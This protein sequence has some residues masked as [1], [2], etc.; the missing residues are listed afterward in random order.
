MASNGKG[1]NGG[2]DPLQ[3][4]GDGLDSVLQQLRNIRRKPIP[5]QIGIGAGAGLYDLARLSAILIELS[6][7][8]G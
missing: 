8:S 2:G 3:A 4:L 6:V 1:N 7:I 5:A